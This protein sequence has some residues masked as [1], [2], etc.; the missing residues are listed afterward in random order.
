MMMRM[1][2]RTLATVEP[3]CRIAPHFTFMQFTN[4]NK[5]G[6]RGAE[7]H[8]CYRQGP[9]LGREHTG[10]IKSRDLDVKSHSTHN[11]WWIESEHRKLHFFFI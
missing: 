11:P 8:S 2:A 7:E 5:P 10:M 4:V 3:T 9:P 6:A 1:R